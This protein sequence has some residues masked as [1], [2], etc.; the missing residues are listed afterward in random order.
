MCKWI[1]M[2]I[3]LAV[4]AIILS[5]PVI[6]WGQANINKAQLKQQLIDLMHQYHL[7]GG[8]VAIIRGGKMLYAH[9]FGWA[10]QYHHIPA[11]S[12]TLFRIA[13]ISKT[14][15]AISM[16]KLAQMYK[17]KLNQPVYSIL[18]DLKPLKGLSLNP[19]AKK[20]T[21]QNLLNMTSGWD[22]WS[23]HAFDPMFDVWPKYYSQIIGHNAP[24]KCSTDARLMLSL[25][26][27]NQPGKQFHY[28]NIN[29]CLLGLVIDKTL[30]KPYD[31]LGYEHFVRRYVLKP[32]GIYDM[33]IGSANI[34]KHFKNEAIY[35][36]NKNYSP[37][38]QRFLSDLPY[39]YDK[40][41]HKNFS[42]GGWL[43]SAQDLAK[44]ANALQSN[45]LLNQH[46][47]HSMLA[48]PQSLKQ[49]HSS[50]KKWHYGMGWFVQN[51]HQYS[52]HGSFSGTNSLLI[53]RPDH[54]IF[55]FIFNK[56]PQPMVKLWRMRQ[57]LYTLAKKIA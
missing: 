32:I 42:D 11:T 28:A 31:Y 56:K 43:A 38:N 4:T 33:K 26:L 3:R 30:K 44:I 47:L 16:L 52:T 5:T 27:S 34:N 55:S 24:M 18:N 36:S 21:L 1:R 51:N 25:P 45:H 15:T 49:R 17:L 19:L 46:S 48:T 12:H 40:I 37:S 6:C 2:S 22:G 35:Y 39:S 8:A 14:I 9:G 41:L 7:P 20:I 10:D 53:I 54:T 23:K 29:Y 50:L 57:T 13:S